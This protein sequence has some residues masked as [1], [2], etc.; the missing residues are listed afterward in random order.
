MEKENPGLSQAAGQ[1]ALTGK[2]QFG[3]KVDTVIT[4]GD[5][6]SKVKDPRGTKV[7]DPRPALPKDKTRGGNVKGDI[8]AEPKV[9]QKKKSTYADFMRDTHLKSYLTK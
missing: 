3:N 4:T 9:T 2:K 6:R 5:E 1:E 7:G 8:A